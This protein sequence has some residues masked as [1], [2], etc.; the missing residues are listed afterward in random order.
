[1]F[2]HVQRW[3]FLVE[4]AGEHPPKAA[5]PLFD[6]EL[7]ERARQPLILPRR[8]CFACAQADHSATN[9]HGLTRA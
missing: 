4:P 9:P 8:A 3:T 7:Y 2:D 1:M 6:V 5:S